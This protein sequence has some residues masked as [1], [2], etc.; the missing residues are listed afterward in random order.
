MFKTL[1]ADLDAVLQRD[2]AARNRM[3]VWLLY[4]GYKAVRKYRRAH[5]F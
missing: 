3:E 4:S 2:P 5:W 1:K